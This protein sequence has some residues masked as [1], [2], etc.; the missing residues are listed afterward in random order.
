MITY[1]LSMLITFILALASIAF[2]TLLER[3]ILGYSQIRKGPNKVTIIGLPQPM[4]D[5][6]KLFTKTPRN[7]TLANLIPFTI[8]PIVR[9]I[10]ALILWIL[11]P[12][13][14][15]RNFIKYGLVF[16]LCISSLS[17]Y[18]TIGI[19]W[20]SN[21]KY[22]LLGAL[23]RIAQTIS[24]EVTLAL[25]IIAVLFTLNTFNLQWT[26]NNSTFILLILSPIIF[27]VWFTCLLA[28]TNRTPF[29]FSEGERELV[30]GF[31]IEYSGSLFA[32]IFISEYINIILVSIISTLLFLQK[33]LSPLTS[34]PMLIIQSLALIIVFILLR[35]TL[36]RIRYDRL[37]NLTWISFLPAR[38][39]FITNI[40]LVSILWHLYDMRPNFFSRR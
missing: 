33:S 4:A 37:M 6:L 38:L 1:S 23:R 24:Y 18:T 40:S 20:S 27:Y 31:N 26:I 17:V 3:K 39:A 13:P 30:S 5:A 28:E 2:F 36:P 35:A 12:T 22:A 29:D 16:F 21:S 7:P 19:G 11:A 34:F 32:F 15:P 8:S 10:L 25:W 9:L 14:N